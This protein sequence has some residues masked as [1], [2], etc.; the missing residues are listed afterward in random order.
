MYQTVVLQIFS[1]I[2]YFLNIVSVI[3]F[4]YCLMTWFVRPDSQM[5]IF[6]RRLIEPIVS[7]FRPLARRLMEK[8]LMLDVSVLLAILGVRVIRYIISFIVFRFLL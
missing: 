3:L 6:M 4:V 5:Y 1:G 7:P 8:G 2:N